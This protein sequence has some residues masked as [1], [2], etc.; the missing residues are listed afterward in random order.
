MAGSGKKWLI[1]CAIA[2]V[3][4]I[5]IVAALIYGGI[6][7][8]RR[9]VERIEEVEAAGGALNDR[10]GD[11]NS[12]VPDADGRIRPERLEAFLNARAATAP[13]RQE[14]ES[15]LSTLDD[16]DSSEGGSGGFLGKGRA[17]LKL[18]PQVFGFYGERADACLQ[19]EIGLG[20]YTYIYVV[21]YYGFL[22]KQVAAG[23]GFDLVTSGDGGNNRGRGRDDFAVR[24]ARR[25]MILSTSRELFLDLLQNQLDAS[26][27]LP[28]PGPEP[29]EA[30]LQ[31]EIEKLQGDPYRLPWNDGLPEQLANSIEPYRERLESSW[32]EM[33]NALEVGPQIH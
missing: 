9:A 12:Y 7:L 4:G 8:G 19:A 11:A 21:A 3:I 31:L 30:E 2:F 32:S 28:R 13:F 22:H 20:E 14:M 23:P 5:L 15:T 18:V 26:R 27:L 24:E 16:S 29:W 33:C 10:F 17:G 1:G 6:Q 25:E